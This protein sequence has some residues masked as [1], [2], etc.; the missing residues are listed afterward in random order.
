M[1]RILFPT[2]FSDVA[3]NAFLHALEFAK[4]VNAELTILHS[5]PLLPVD[6]NFFAENFNKVYETIQ[7]AEFDMFK[8]EVPK[9]RAIAEACHLDKIKMS[10]RLM[11]G[12]L[13]E[14]IIRLVDEEKI[15]YVVMGTSGYSNW[16][17][18][19]AGSNSGEVVMEVKVPVLCI[20]KMVQSKPIKIIGFTTRFRDKDRK[21]LKAAAAFAASINAYIR[22]LYVKTPDSDVPKETI[23]SWKEEFKMT[24][25][26]FF[27]EEN[28]S[29]N[30]AV[31]DFI[32]EKN[33]DLLTILTYKRGFFKGLF[34][35]TYFEKPDSEIHIPILAFPVE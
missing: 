8:E 2:D 16:D 1:K 12:N 5:Y 28:D 13:I 34:Q 30:E 14:N 7:L 29:V 35:P 3:T 6:E 27:I 18:A 33:I 19:F 21:A 20:P 25:V 24:P 32:D 4:L 22:C 11:E 9:L 23:A 15:D 26:K 17:A 10:H 31:L